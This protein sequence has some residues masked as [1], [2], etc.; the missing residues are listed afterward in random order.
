MQ[1]GSCPGVLAR[2]HLL[3]VFSVPW[4]TEQ[5]QTRSHLMQKESLRKQAKDT[6]KNLFHSKKA[7]ADETDMAQSGGAGDILQPTSLPKVLSG[8][9]SV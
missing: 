4:R 1:Q 7:H 9:I 5:A 8:G 2:V 6:L 3:A